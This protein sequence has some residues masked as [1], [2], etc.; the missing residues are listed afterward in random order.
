MKHFS[1]LSNFSKRNACSHDP[2]VIKYNSDY[3]NILMEVIS[4]IYYY[5]NFYVILRQL[6]IT[7]C[8]KKN[9]KIRRSLHLAC[10]HSASLRSPFFSSFTRLYVRRVSSFATPSVFSVS[11]AILHLCGLKFIYS[12]SCRN[13]EFCKTMFFSRYAADS[14]SLTGGVPKNRLVYSHESRVA[15][16]ATAVRH[17]SIVTVQSFGV[18]ATDVAMRH[19]ANGHGCQVVV[20]LLAEFIAR[21]EREGFLSLSLF[22]FLSLFLRRVLK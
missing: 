17:K 5:R 10:L 8:Y 7:Y 12:G 19:R 18:S 20:R 22:F 13:G 21:G 14:G 2:F 11:R 6:P 4:K 16:T 15:S 9:F 1:I 3:K